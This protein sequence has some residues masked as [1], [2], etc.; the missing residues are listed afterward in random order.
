MPLLIRLQRLLDATRAVDFLAPLA[1]RL[2]LAPVFWM[3]GTNKLDGLLPS[4]NTV[5]WFG[6]AEW[7]LGLPMPWLMAF[8]AAYTE[9][10]GAI[11]LLV[12]I[13]VRWFSIPLMVTMLVAAFAVHW[14][15]GWQ[16]IA[17]PASCLFNCEAA[18]EAAKRLDVAK[19]ILQEHGNYA[20]LTEQGGIAISNNGIEFAATYFVMLLT[21][22]F[23]GAGRY[24]SVDYFIRRRLMPDLQ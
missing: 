19:N 11:A 4:A 18:Q 23:V 14:K 7:G 22:F 16:A 21:L 3:A 24:L 17:D 5:A 8:L 6:N 20:W 9:V 13:A 15:N 10:L 2:Y 12:G 1:L